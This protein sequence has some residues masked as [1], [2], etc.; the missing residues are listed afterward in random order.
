MLI[1][2]VGIHIPIW[3]SLIFVA[4]VLLSSVAASL[5]WPKEAELDIEVDLPEGFDPPFEDEEEGDLDASAETDE[6]SESELNQELKAG[7][8]DP[9]SEI[10]EEEHENIG[11]R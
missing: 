1:V 6:A 5:L 3:I 10:R 2:A 4:T 11:R 9:K 7:E 8:A